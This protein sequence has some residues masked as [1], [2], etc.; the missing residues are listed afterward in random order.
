MQ[1]TD[2]EL[3]IYNSCEDQG[4][5]FSIYNVTWRHQGYA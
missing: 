5:A 1:L 4:D 2:Q 3:K